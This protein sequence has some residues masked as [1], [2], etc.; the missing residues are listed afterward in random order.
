MWIKVEAK[1][2]KIWKIEWN[3]KRKERKIWV[4]VSWEKCSFA[5]ETRRNYSYNG[6]KEWEGR[7]KEK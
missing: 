6:L 1:M 7:R 2:N 3:T 5:T 4:K